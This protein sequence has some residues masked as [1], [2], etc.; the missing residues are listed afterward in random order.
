MTVSRQQRHT[1]QHRCQI[2]GGADEDPRGKDK[3]CNGFTSADGWVHCSRE[4]HAGRLEQG[5]DSLYAHRPAGPCK[6]GVTHREDTR[7][8]FADCN[9]EE[10]YDYRNADGTIRFRV[11][12]YFGKEFRQWQPDGMGGWIQERPGSRTNP[13]S[14]SRAS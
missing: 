3:R 14:P 8:R 13:L 12:R 5:P 1:R 11:V 7:S 4:E 6:C 10:T 9:I 2:C